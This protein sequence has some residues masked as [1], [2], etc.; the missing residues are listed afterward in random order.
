MHLQHHLNKFESFVHTK[1]RKQITNSHKLDL[2][3]L[4]YMYQLNYKTLVIV[5]FSL[6]S[7]YL[8]VFYVYI[9]LNF[10][11]IHQEGLSIWTWTAHEEES[12]F[13]SI[14][15][16]IRFNLQRLCLRIHD[17][18][19]KLLQTLRPILTFKRLHHH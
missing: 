1:V 4:L 15:T 11:S 16:E 7:R 9:H 12:E 18:F 13:S 2:I 8:L 17:H 5:L 3:H 19:R 14:F 6:L 10:R